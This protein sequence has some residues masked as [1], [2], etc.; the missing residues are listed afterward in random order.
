LEPLTAASRTSRVA[1][2]PL[3]LRPPIGRNLESKSTARLLFWSASDKSRAVRGSR[4][5]FRPVYAKA[6]SRGIPLAAAL[7]II[8]QT[9][10]APGGSSVCL[11]G[12][13]VRGERSTDIPVRATGWKTRAPV[14]MPKVIGEELGTESLWTKMSGKSMRFRAKQR[15]FAQNLWL[16]RGGTWYSGVIVTPFGKGVRKRHDENNRSDRNDGTG[17]GDAACE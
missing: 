3:L 15:V 14:L 9:C 4:H 12:R 7:Q 5:R 1:S 13:A 10:E 2:Q 11:T 6:A 17:G 16:N 8:Y